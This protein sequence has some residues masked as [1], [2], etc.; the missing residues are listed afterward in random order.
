METEPLDVVSIHVIGLEH[1]IVG[2]MRV[3][4]VETVSYEKVSGHAAHRGR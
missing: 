3:H 4:G 1:Q 2:P